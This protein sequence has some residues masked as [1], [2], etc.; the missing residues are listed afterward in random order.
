M[1]STWL[2]RE[3]NPKT[4]AFWPQHQVLVLKTPG[5]GER[6][7]N[8]KTINSFT[9]M[10]KEKTP[11]SCKL[12][13]RSL[14]CC[15]QISLTPFSLISDSCLNLLW[16]DHGGFQDKAKRKLERGHRFPLLH[17]TRAPSWFHTSTYHL[18]L[19]FLS[20]SNNMEKETLSCAALQSSYDFISHIKLNT[21]SLQY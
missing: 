6:A 1:V 8:K 17:H 19:A 7:L 3:M 9:K 11:Q 13:Q 10:T 18:C 14:P 5:W 2:Q 16:D 4:P 20:A 21:W 12:A 15:W